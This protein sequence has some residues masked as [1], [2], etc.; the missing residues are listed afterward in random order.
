MRQKFSARA[1]GVAAGI[2]LLLFASAPT[3][4]AIHAPA[5]PPPSPV[6][7][8]SG[9]PAIQ[10]KR[11]YYHRARITL[12]KRSGRGRTYSF[13]GWMKKGTRACI[14]KLERGGR[15]DECGGD[16]RWAHLAG[17]R[18]WVAGMCLEMAEK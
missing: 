12:A 9:A 13:M 16:N 6:A 15:Y 11:C 3:A 8:K 10:A 14:D 1:V 18:S 7:L 4:E 2:S 5:L 17:T